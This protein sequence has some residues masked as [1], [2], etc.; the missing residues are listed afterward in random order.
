VE[1]IAT[2]NAKKV[3]YQSVRGRGPVRIDL[4]AFSWAA[5]V[6]SGGAEDRY[7]REILDACKKGK[8][9][10]IVCSGEESGPD[11]EFF[12]MET[13]E[14]GEP[15]DGRFE[16]PPCVIQKESL[17]DALWFSLFHATCEDGELNSVVCL[18]GTERGVKNYLKAQA[19]E[20]NKDESYLSPEPGEEKIE[21]DS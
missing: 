18:D 13:F 4:P 19:E 7:Y 1:T 12:D 20:M 14:I 16:N 10:Y 21:Y 6:I 8:C 11:Y 15:A 2:V 9:G 17:A 3:Y 5:L